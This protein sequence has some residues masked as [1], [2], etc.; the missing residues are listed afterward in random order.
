MEMAVPIKNQGDNGNLLNFHLTAA[1]I[2]K[3]LVLE[4][5]H[6]TL[7]KPEIGKNILAARP[8]L[9]IVLVESQKVGDPSMDTSNYQ[10]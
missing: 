6:F 1:G 9:N 7:R 10:R 5:L 8:V 3:T 2:L 4:T